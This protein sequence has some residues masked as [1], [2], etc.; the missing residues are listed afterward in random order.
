MS[1]STTPSSISAESRATVASSGP[2]ITLWTLRLFAVLTTT[3]TLAQPLLAG[4]Y[5]DGSVKAILVHG[6]NGHLLLVLV[7]AQLIAAIPYRFAG[8]GAGWPLH[9]SITL[10]IAVNL[11]L[12]F[13]YGRLLT[14]HLPLGIAI[15]ACQ[16]GI[17]IWLWS[18]AARRAHPRRR[19]RKLERQR[20]QQDRK[21]RS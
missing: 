1:N 7:F 3:A 12:G 14:A 11:Q 15:L 9:A 21:V 18:P 10:L 16:L 19:R 8:R 13:G 4:A 17:T 6:N 5:L 20:E 2:R